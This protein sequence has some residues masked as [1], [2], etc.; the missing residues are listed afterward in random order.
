MIPIKVTPNDPLTDRVIPGKD[1]V[2]EP[3]K[4]RVSSEQSPDDEF[5]RWLDDLTVGLPPMPSLSADFS[6][7]ELYPDDE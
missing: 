6:R 4:N 1:V 3:V 5:D 7:H 2:S